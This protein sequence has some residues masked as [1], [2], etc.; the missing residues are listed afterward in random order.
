MFNST[1][2]HR[3]RGTPARSTSDVTDVDGFF[4]ISLLYVDRKLFG[5]NVLSL[6]ELLYLLASV[7]TQLTVCHL[8]Q[9]AG[10]IT[11]VSY[12][13]CCP[14]YRA[15]IRCDSL[16]FGDS[17]LFSLVSALRQ[18]VRKVE[19]YKKHGGRRLGIDASGCKRRLETVCIGLH[20]LYE[21]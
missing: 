2:N 21:G 3:V 10:D 13:S 14:R 18:K 11:S 8:W 16:H 15:Y 1:L 17:L 7:S 5:M 19:M 4:F 6:V 9:R 12:T 20:A